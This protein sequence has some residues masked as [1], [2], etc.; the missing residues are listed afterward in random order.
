MKIFVGC[1]SKNDLDAMYY[2]A[3]K[4]IA[5]SLQKH[6][7]ILGGSQEGLMG[8]IDANIPNSQKN[9]I[10]LD[11]YIPEN[12]DYFEVKTRKCES[13]F[14]RLS[15]I[16][17]LADFFLFLP[18]GI[19]TISE[20]ICFLEENR[21]DLKKKIIVFNQ[22]AYYNELIS[23]INQSK[24]LKFSDESVLSGIEFISDL[25]EVKKRLESL[26]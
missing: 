15:Q 13:S 19:G 18:G 2:E 8:V 11:C 25:E 12:Y 16:W 3:A 10:I 23:F 6:Q 26:T 5:K 20:I 14:E 7:V 24:N 21:T 4:E 17:N 1:S 9:R 22:N